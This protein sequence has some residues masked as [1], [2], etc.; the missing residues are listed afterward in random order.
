MGMASGTELRIRIKECPKISRNLV[1]LISLKVFVQWQ[2]EERFVL[3]FGPCSTNHAQIRFNFRSDLNDEVILTH[4]C[5]F[6]KLSASLNTKS[7]PNIHKLRY[8]DYQFD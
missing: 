7:L 1:E 5:K 8:A 3:F 4:L 2:D 6:L